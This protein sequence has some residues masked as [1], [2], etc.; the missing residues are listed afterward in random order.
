MEKNFQLG[1]NL[2]S[3]EHSPNDL[4]KNARLAE[5]TGFDFVM[6]SDHYHP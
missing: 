3:E 2:S 6:I 4:V 1:Y 5:E